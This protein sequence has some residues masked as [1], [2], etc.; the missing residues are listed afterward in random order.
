MRDYIRKFMQGGVV[1]LSWHL[2]NHLPAKPPQG[3][4][5]G[6]MLPV[7]PGGGKMIYTNP[8]SIKIADFIGSLRGLQKNNEAM[9]SFSGLFT[10][11][12]QLVLVG[13][14]PY[15]PEEYKQ[16]FQFTVAYLRDTKTCTNLNCFPTP[17]GIP[18]KEV[19]AKA[20]RRQMGWHYWLRYLSTWGKAGRQNRAIYKGT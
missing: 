13:Q 18:G 10:V 6:T 11:E 8:G 19:H 1:T 7:L 5:P 12:W 2:N 14:R 16:L 4:A 3:P 15:T 9:P 20:S 17:T